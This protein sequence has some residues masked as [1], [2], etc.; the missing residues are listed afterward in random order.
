MRSKVMIVDDH[1]LF[2]EGLQYLLEVYGIKVVGRARTGS[3][4][5]TKARILKPDIILMDIMM[6]EMNG[7]EVLK[8][9][10]AEMPS[11]KVLMLTTSEDDEHLFEAIKHGASGYLIKNTDGKELISR[12]QQAENGEIPLSPGLASKILLELNKKYDNTNKSIKKSSMNSEQEKLSDKQ[13]ELLKI[14]A[15]GK[16]YRRAGEILG[17]SERT[18]KYHM[19]RIIEILQLDN[20]AQV[21]AYAVENG[22]VDK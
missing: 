13:N 8:I 6:P 14:I 16:T 4:A 5:I 12:L 2:L 1:Q 19:G 10:V 11:I 20:K 17:L 3:E 9:I 7:L 22:L 18:V 15:S 21:I